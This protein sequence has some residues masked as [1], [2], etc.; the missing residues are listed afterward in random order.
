MK[1][2]RDGKFLLIF[3]STD[4]A[5][6]IAL[7]PFRRRWLS[8]LFKRYW[9]GRSFHLFFPLFFSH[10]YFIYSTVEYDINSTTVRVWEYCMMCHITRRM[11]FLATGF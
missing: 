10:S 3:R 6:G 4:D 2:K 9:S 1:M 11:Y 7:V 8:T 5:G